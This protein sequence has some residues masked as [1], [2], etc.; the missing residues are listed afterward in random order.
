MTDVRL[1]GDVRAPADPRAAAGA[2]LSGELA[3][4]RP[5]TTR[6]R[7]TG[8]WIVWLLGLG[9]TAQCDGAGRGEPVAHVAAADTGFV[10]P[11]QIFCGKHRIYDD[12]QPSAW[13]GVPNTSDTTIG[14]DAAGNPVCL[15]DNDG[16]PNLIP[17]LQHAELRGWLVHANATPNTAIDA[18]GNH[19]GDVLVDDENE[20]RFDL[21]LDVGWQPDP[22]AS[23]IGDPGT[24][25]IN[26][27]ARVRQYISPGDII[28]RARRNGAS[29]MVG[30]VG[31]WG[32]AMNDVGG[33]AGNV[34]V[35]V[36]V[37]GWGP[38]RGGAFYWRQYNLF[39]G[40][41]GPPGW[42]K[43]GMEQTYPPGSYIGP[44][45]PWYPVF[46]PFSLSPNGRPYQAGDYVSVIGTLWQDNPHIICHFFTGCDGGLPT[47]A[48]ECWADATNG[49]S[50]FSSELHAP[51]YMRLIKPA[52]ADGAAAV[53]PTDVSHSLIAYA[54]CRSP[55]M[56]DPQTLNPPPGNYA[57]SSIQYSVDGQPA[58]S[59]PAS[60]VGTTATFSAPPTA[61]ALVM[62][63]VT[64]A[65]PP[66]LTRCGDVCVSLASDAAHCGACSNACATGARCSAGACVAG[67]VCGDSVCSVGETCASCPS[68]CGACSY[69]GDGSCDPGESCRSC[70][71]DCGACPCRTGTSDCCGDGVCR[72]AKACAAACP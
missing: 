11:S 49:Y 58:V 17:A 55:G 10:R 39:G 51:D 23:P 35:H 63:D 6:A 47:A 52:I 48:Q 24:T 34:V 62:Y 65:C 59:A 8:A 21:I 33:V 53:A 70:P 31:T 67:P 38:G 56:T 46:W 9:A 71:D 41:Y 2:P 15:S 30:N 40:Y 64:W 44:A 29:A 22:I 60:F 32:G 7:W 57:I 19:V 26:T 25:P 54:L 1:H 27:L 12:N 28:Q 69:C 37:D 18:N 45:N 14:V 5:G 36:E 13:S 42:V 16:V 20:W 66:G 3:S 50:Y 61:A 43:Q 72:A 68:D 4:S